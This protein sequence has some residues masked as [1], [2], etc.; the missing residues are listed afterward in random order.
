MA[1]NT[2]RKQ[3]VHG[4]AA[5][6][7][8]VVQQLF[9]CVTSRSFMLVEKTHMTFGLVFAARQI[10]NTGKKVEDNLVVQSDKS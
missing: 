6:G 9:S 8:N 1:L 2:A 3:E 10:C 5:V 7:D 4:N